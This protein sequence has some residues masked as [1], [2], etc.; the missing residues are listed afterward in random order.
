MKIHIS[1]KKDLVNISFYK[2]NYEIVKKLLIL[3]DI[4][5]VSIL[6][7]EGHRYSFDRFLCVDE[8]EE[9]LSKNK[10]S[11]IIFNGQVPICIMD[12]ELEILLSKI[13]MIDYNLGENL[14]TI[15]IN[16]NNTTI[17]KEKIKETL[18]EVVYKTK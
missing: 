12:K 16:L 18:K 6:I 13:I 3:L 4:D 2:I 10:Q 8:F 15:L 9:Y 17:T 7:D 5:I 1:S 14:T 11:I